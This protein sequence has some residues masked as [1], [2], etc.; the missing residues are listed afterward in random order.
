MDVGES[1]TLQ[2]VKTTSEHQL[3]QLLINLD[4]DLSDI[5]QDGNSAFYYSLDKG[6][7]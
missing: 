2:I 7:Y 4:A 5:D 6:F 3:V 1:P